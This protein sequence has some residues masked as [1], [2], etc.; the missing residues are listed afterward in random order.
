M[1]WTR[2]LLWFVLSVGCGSFLT[3]LSC[4]YVHEPRSLFVDTVPIEYTQLQFG[5]PLPVFGYVVQLYSGD[6]LFYDALFIWVGALLDVVF[7]AFIV[8]TVFLIGS[9]IART[10]NARASLKQLK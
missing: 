5:F 1:R 8:G 3:L 6:H 9:K 10:V 2:A 7:Y 4:F